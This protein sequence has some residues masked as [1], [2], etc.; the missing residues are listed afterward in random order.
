MRKL[1]SIIFKII[2]TLI[3]FIILAIIIIFSILNYK[4]NHYYNYLETNAKLESEY[5]HLGSYEINSLSIEADDEVIK[6]YSIY[7][8]TELE[9]SDTNYPIVVIANGTGI[10]AS[11]YQSFFK[12]LASWDF[13]VIGNEDENSRTGE[14]SSKSLDLMISLNNN[15]ESIFYKKVDTE[16]IGIVGHSQGGV[17]VINA[18]NN[19]NNGIMYKAM[20]TASA[21]SPFW[22]QD[23]QLGSEWSYDVSL[24][25]IPY[26]F[27]AGTGYF[28]AGEAT[29][30]DETTGQGI[31]P[32]YAM[33]DIYNHLNNEYKIM[34]RLVDIDHGDT[35]KK[36]DSYMTAWFLYWL[37]NDKEASNIFFGD[38]AEILNNE[39][40]QDIKKSF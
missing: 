1:I 40:W 23:S 25:N 39:N 30:I 31:C 29:S 15:K 32:L 22:G 4:N 17:A 33:E 3:I 21:T 38:N 11:K 10:P 26:F 5:A 6:K 14:S 12:H 35:Y 8:P 7:Y 24:I 2:V 28:D 37:K 13:I 36:A 19:W 9:N 18:V 34:G 16:N 20:Y 27:I